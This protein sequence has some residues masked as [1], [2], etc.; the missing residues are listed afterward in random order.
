MLEMALTAESNV[1]WFV[2]AAG[3]TL[4]VSLETQINKC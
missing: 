2:G 1:T 3:L 4:M